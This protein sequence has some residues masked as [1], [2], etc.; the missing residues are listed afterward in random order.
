MPS[1]IKTTLSG[2][3]KTLP[4]GVPYPKMHIKYNDYF[5]PFPGEALFIIF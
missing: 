5:N 4:A 3:D 2:F 1:N